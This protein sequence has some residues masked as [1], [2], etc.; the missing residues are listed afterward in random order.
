MNEEWISDR[1][2]FA[3]DGLKRQ[4]LLNPM[5]ASRTGYEYAEWEVALSVCEKLVS[6]AETSPYTILAFIL[7]FVILFCVVFAG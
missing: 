5:L 4:R 6:H 7:L 3:Y 1:T 2:R